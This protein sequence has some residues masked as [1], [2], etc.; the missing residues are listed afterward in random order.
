[1]KRF[2][3]LFLAAL[4]STGAMTQP[5][6]IGGIN[7]N[8]NQVPW[9]VSLENIASGSTHFCGGSIISNRW[10][11]TAAHCV[12]AATGGQPNAAQIRVHAGAT[13]Q[14]NNAVGQR[15]VCDQVI[16]HPQFNP[17]TL[18][19]DIALLHL[20]ANL[21]FTADV[22]QVRYSTA[23]NTPDAAIA[24]G[25]VSALTGWGLTC[26]TCPG[27]NI[28]QRVNIPIITAQQAM[29]IQLANNPGN[30]N[31]I[32]AN[33]IAHFQNGA[34]AAPGDSG[35]PATIWD[36]NG[37]PVLIG[38]CSWGYWPKDINPTMY[39][40]IRNYAAWVQ[41]NT[42][43]N[44]DLLSGISG[45]DMICTSATYSIP[46]LPATAIV[47]WSTS[48]QPNM[49]TLSC[50]TCPQV[51]ATKG[52]TSG[53]NEW[54]TATITGCGPTQ[55]F[56]KRVRVGAYNSTSN[57]TTNGIHQ[58]CRNQTSSITIDGTNYPGL[59][60][61]TWG[62][63]PANWTM[64]TSGSNYAVLR[65][66]STTSPPT[67]SLPVTAT[68]VCGTSSTAY[69]F[70]AITTAPNC[71][72]MRIAPNPAKDVVNI[73]M[74]D[75]ATGKPVELPEYKV[76]ELVSKTGILI[77]RHNITGKSLG[78]RLSIPVAELKND[79]YTLR[80]FDGKDWMSYKVIVQH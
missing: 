66:G 52:S 71:G 19:N 24:P 20:S 4:C 31:P 79:V 11:L 34:A 46:N 42:G 63:A 67:G 21:N 13:D 6:I 18:D 65:S 1:M 7:I 22:Q 29:A 61:I 70:M 35:G 59:T 51:T 30:T 77:R 74:L 28:L 76:Y 10:I 14:T 72:T 5:G 44:P 16:V 57:F 26:N 23:C 41:T 53:G 15:I 32:T 58:W 37:N 78:T 12:S 39:T 36:A 73:E 68:N 33:M 49:L 8:I 3:F 56:T 50:T 25:Q 9:Q 27:S 62:A 54:I 64:I 40:R 2:M 43:I 45:P 69:H 55:T 80:I 75:E 60:S 38:A 47:T 48:N 17:T